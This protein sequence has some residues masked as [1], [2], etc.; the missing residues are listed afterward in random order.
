[1]CVCVCE[2]RHL[3]SFFGNLLKTLAQT[4]RWESNGWSRWP[5]RPLQP[6]WYIVTVQLH[7][8][9][10]HS[11]T[12]TICHASHSK[13]ELEVVGA[14]WNH[15]L[16]F[17]ALVVGTVEIEEDQAD[18]G[19][20]DK[21]KWAALV[22]PAVVPQQLMHVCTKRALHWRVLHSI[23]YVTRQGDEDGTSGKKLWILGWY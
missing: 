3:S 4:A 10:C 21:R 16:T 22:Q 20:N 9:N 8:E 2:Q 17:K 15:R 11:A 23:C 1:M 7:R 13:G 14:A 6:R 12:P 5:A 18:S 19:R